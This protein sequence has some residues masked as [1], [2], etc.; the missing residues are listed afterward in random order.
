MAAVR[1]PAMRMAGVVVAAVLLGSAGCARPGGSALPSVSLPTGPS[2]SSV[3]SV[4]PS[5]PSPSPRPP[6]PVSPPT[7]ST[8]PTLPASLLG[9]QW[10]RLPT[11]DKVVALTFDAGAGA[12][13]AGPILQTLRETGAA[14]T[15]FLT[16]RWAETYPNLAREI[17]ARYPVGNHTYDHPDLTKPS[18]ADVRQQLDR[19][20]EAILRH[21]GVDPRP[22]F[23]F[24]FGAASPHAIALVNAAGYGAVA[25][26]VD[27]RGWM[28]TSGGQ[29][30]DTVVQR[31]LDAL[32]PGAIVIMHVGANP[33][34][35]S[36]LDADAL[37]RVIAEIR[38]RGYD[39]V[40]ISAFL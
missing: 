5:T 12:T 11:T 19:A 21:A 24:P 7:P 36:T 14:A 34:D 40:A 30:V 9:T 37:P 4:L 2:P 17:G 3:P 39:F 6:P 35:G 28:G 13:G 8:G 31:V 1:G 25:W 15:F 23:R 33:Q 38:A 20:R 32:Q 22:L 29:S 10:Y 16:G 18:D 27:T 26:T